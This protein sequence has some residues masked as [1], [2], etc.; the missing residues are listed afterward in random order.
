MLLNTRLLQSW[1]HVLLEPTLLHLLRLGLPSSLLHH[2]L[3]LILLLI[4]L[5]L[6]SGGCSRH[7]QCRTSSTGASHLRRCIAVPSRA[8][9]VATW[10]SAPWTASCNRLPH[11]GATGSVGLANTS[12]RIVRHIGSSHVWRRPSAHLVSKGRRTRHASPSLLLLSLRP[13]RTRRPRS[14]RIIRRRRPSRHARRVRGA[15][16]LCRSSSASR[17]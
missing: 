12:G 10:C 2:R 4:L 17:P 15:A 13:T 9:V 5:L 8:R 11:G 16:D 14:A 3:L 6:H 1:L 7:E